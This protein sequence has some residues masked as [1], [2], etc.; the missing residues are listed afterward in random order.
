MPIIPLYFPVSSTWGY[1]QIYL[2]HAG[3]QLI[4]NF[5]ASLMMELTIMEPDVATLIGRGDSLIV[6]QVPKVNLEWALS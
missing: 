3:Y 4:Y 5:L 1:G 6:L 2:K